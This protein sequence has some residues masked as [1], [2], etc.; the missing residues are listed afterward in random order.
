MFVNLDTVSNSEFKPLDRICGNFMLLLWALQL[1]TDKMI[2]WVEFAYNLWY[3]IV[4][5]VLAE[6]IWHLTE[7]LD[8]VHRLRAGISKVNGC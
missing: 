1:I 4:R 6:G 8:H 5:Y 2:F 7:G 3:C